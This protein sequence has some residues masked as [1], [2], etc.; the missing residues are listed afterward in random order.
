LSN[1]L[2]KG[3][4]LIFGM[5]ILICIYQLSQYTIVITEIYQGNNAIYNNESEVI[6]IN[7][8]NEDNAE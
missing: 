8:N 2:F 4:T 1:D 7:E 5:I 3:L 6:T